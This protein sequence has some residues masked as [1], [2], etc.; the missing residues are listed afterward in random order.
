M[1]KLWRQDLRVKK[2]LESNK[3]LEEFD[4]TVFEN[5]VDKIIV[6]G[7]NQDGEINPA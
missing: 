6:G 2:L 1:K 3:Y 7:I 4:G 5:I